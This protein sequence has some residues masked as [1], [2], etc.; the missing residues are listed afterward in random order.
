MSSFDFSAS[1]GTA[2]YSA[3]SGNQIPE[4]SLDVKARPARMADNLTAISEPIFYKNMGSSK[5]HNPI[6]PHGLSPR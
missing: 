4:I 3:S 6:G 2:F 5:S 1:L